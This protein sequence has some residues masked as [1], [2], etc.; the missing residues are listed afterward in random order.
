MPFRM[1]PMEMI[2]GLTAVMLVVAVM[3]V[4]AF[5]RAFVAGLNG[6]TDKS[7]NKH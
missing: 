6:P 2:L 1:G 5:L 7:A 3:F 4:R